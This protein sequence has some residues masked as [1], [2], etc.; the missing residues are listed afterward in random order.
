MKKKKPAHR[1][2]EKQCPV[3]GVLHKK[4]WQ[5]CSLKCGIEFRSLTPPTQEAVRARAEGV[6]RW[7]FTDKGEATNTNLK[8]YMND[9]DFALPPEQH[10]NDYFLE[11][12]DI[13]SPANI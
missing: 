5:C 3:C 2:K 10:D 7:K 11:D 6:R 8:Q 1:Y 9:D 12:G 4:R 13:W